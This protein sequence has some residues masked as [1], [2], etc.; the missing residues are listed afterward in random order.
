VDAATHALIAEPT[1][2][3]TGDWC[4]QGY[5]FYTD[6]MI[7]KASLDVPEG[8]A[9][10]VVVALDRF[11]GTVAAVWANGKKAAVLGWRPYEADVTD[12]V[13]MGRNE[14]GIEIVGSP[15]NLMG[16]RHSAEKYPVWVGAEQIADTR[17]PG[18]HLS[19][20]GLYG[21]VQVRFHESSE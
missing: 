14:I 19:P 17:E 15:R 2:L 20:A 7:Y 21:P 18:Y 5:P 4:Q 12:F 11:E 6:G 9:G 1:R 8:F 13:K 10:R 3:R 16:P